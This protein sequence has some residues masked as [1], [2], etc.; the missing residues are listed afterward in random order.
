MLGLFSALFATGQFNRFS[1][2]VIAPELMRDLALSA[3]QVSTA[4]A[5][6]F[7][8]SALAQLPI[9]V[10]LDRWGPKRT[11]TVGVLAGILG[12]LLLA[13]A[14]G[15]AQLVVSRLLIG[16]GFSTV[17][18]SAFVV[19]ARWFAADRFASKSSLMLGV[20]GMGSLLA[21]SPLA[22]FI[23]S[24]GWRAAFFTVAAVAGTLLCVAWLLVRDA[25]DG[26]KPRQAARTESLADNLRGLMTVL[27]HPGM[28]RILSIALVSFAPATTMIGLWAGPYLRDVHGLDAVPRGHVLLAMGLA[29]NIGL[30]C[31]GPLDRRLD[32]RKKVVLAGAASQALMFALLAGL[33]GV[34][35]WLGAALLVTQGLLSNFYIVLHAHTRAIVPEH[36]TGRAVTLV[37]LCCVMGVFLMQVASG[38]LIGAFQQADGRAPEL[39]YRL[40]FGLIAVAMALGLAG[41]C[42]VADA[43]PSMTKA[44]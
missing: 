41:Y 23:E 38:L 4:I 36:L 44:S 10:A 9:G 13:S 16:A 29:A 22:M 5:V 11:L 40:L 32:T 33:D 18:V 43:R 28:W 14:Q 27:R 24:H 39:A 3:T 20:A 12:V 25:P 8:A 7:L 1:G 2:G 42:R 17:M 26:W 31:Y 15:M 6:L 21:T 37:N 34:T 35:L 30:I 19:F